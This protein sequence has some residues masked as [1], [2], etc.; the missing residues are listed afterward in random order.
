MFS[1]REEF[2]A[3]DHRREGMVIEIETGVKNDG[4]ITARRGRLVSTTAPTRPTRR[5][6]PQIAI[7]HVAGPYKTQRRPA[8]RTCVYTNLQPSGSVRAPT[9][10]QVCWAVEQ[11]T[12]EVARAIGMDPVEFRRKQ[13]HRRGRRGPDAAGLPG[14]RHAECLEHAA[15]MIGYGQELPEDEAIGIGCGWWPTFGVP[16]GGVREAQRATARA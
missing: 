2:I 1:R 16:V 5:S 14:D 11:H 9:A 13:L 15:E 10:P 6:S 8:T 4:T 7:M 12:D 3:P